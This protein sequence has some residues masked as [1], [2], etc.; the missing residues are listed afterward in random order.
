MLDDAGG[1]VFFVSQRRADIHAGRFQAMMASRGDVLLKRKLI[2][3]AGQQ[4]NV[5][6]GFTFIEAIQRMT[7][8]DTSLAAGTAIEIDLKGVLLAVGGGVAGKSAA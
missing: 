2:V 7:R 5:A 6:P 1:R 3:S 8:T 4:S